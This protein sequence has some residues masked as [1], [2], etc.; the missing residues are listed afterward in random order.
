[1]NRKLKSLP[2]MVLLAVM[3]IAAACAPRYEF[4]PVPIRPLEGYSNLINFNG[5]LVGAHAVY[6]SKEVVKFFGFDL[7]KAGVIPIQL[8]VKN[9]LPQESLILA[10]ANL[11]D[12]EGLLWEVLPSDVVVRRIDEHTSGGLSGDQGLR[13]SLLWGLAGGVLGAAI[14]VA[15]G[16]SVAEAAGKG[17]AVGAAIGVT[18]SIAQ[19]GTD[20]SSDAGEIQRDFSTRDIDHATIKAGETVNGLLYFPAESAQPKRLKLTFKTAAGDTNVEVPL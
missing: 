8:S 3:L 2:V 20:T 19:A 17:A 4:K 15:S 1:M 13:R 6:D 12:A 7:K 9:N 14:G 5:G 16:T 18:S 11:L 10:K